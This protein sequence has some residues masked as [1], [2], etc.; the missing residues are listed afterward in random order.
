MIKGHQSFLLKKLFTTKKTVCPRI[1]VNKT[2]I[3][4]TACFVSDKNRQYCP[5][6]RRRKDIDKILMKEKDLFPT[7]S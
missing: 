2:K 1:T 3:S 4:P 6:K 7:S 5:C